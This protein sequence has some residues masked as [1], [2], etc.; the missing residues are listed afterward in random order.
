[1]AEKTE[2]LIEKI[3]KLTGKKTE[4]AEK[5]ISELQKVLDSN[6]DEVSELVEESKLVGHVKDA[7]KA[8]GATETILNKDIA[9]ATESAVRENIEKAGGLDKS[10]FVE[11]MRHPRFNE[12]M[13][14]LADINSRIFTKVK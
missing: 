10:T 5:L 4:K 2:S 13:E 11:F 1:M 12:F 6:T 7:L 9:G 3:K 14:D 8:G